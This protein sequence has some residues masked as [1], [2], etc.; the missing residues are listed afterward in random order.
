MKGQD[1]VR[2]ISWATKF[3]DFS[4]QPDTKVLVA[5]PTEKTTQLP[6]YF[7][8][9]YW[10]NPICHYIYFFE[11]QLLNEDPDNNGYYLPVQ[12][13]YLYYDT[14]GTDSKFD[15]YYTDGSPII[16]QTNRRIDFNVNIDTS[17]DPN[18]IAN[19]I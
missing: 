1:V 16:S 3:K 2:K 7:I 4:F 17:N 6:E 13:W 8:F 10:D 19:R 18:G 9:G 14:L 12:I 5:C 15:I 11:H